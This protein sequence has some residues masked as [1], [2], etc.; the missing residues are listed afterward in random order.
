MAK[1]NKAKLQWRQKQFFV[2]FK[3]KFPL[4]AN[5]SNQ[6]NGRGWLF[7]Q[8]MTKNHCPKL[9]TKANENW[10]FLLSKSWYSYLHGHVTVCASYLPLTSTSC[11]SQANKL[12]QD[13]SHGFITANDCGKIEIS[14]AFYSQ[15]GTLKVGVVR[16]WGLAASDPHHHTSDPFVKV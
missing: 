5:F 15:H 16:A 8:F 10:S 3:G 14:L 1:I 6:N 12:F 7:T 11:S 9:W 4:S 2:S 13:G